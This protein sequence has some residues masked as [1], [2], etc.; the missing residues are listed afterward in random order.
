MPDSDDPTIKELLE[1]GGSMPLDPSTQADL[2]RWFGLPSVTQLEEEGKTA[3]AEDEEMAQVIERRN[4]ALA[5]V[6]PALLAAING[7]TE[8]RPV[9]IVF[10]PSIDLVID[11]KT[12]FFDHDMLDRIAAIADP[13]EVELSD[14]LLD[15]LKECTPQ[16]LLRDL[17]RPESF[18]DKT[19]EWV[20]PIGEG[21]V[22]VVGEVKTAMAT[23]LRLRNFGSRVELEESRQDLAA[24][25]AERRR[26]WLEY[27]PLLQNR[28]V[29]E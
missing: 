17:H 8:D 4:K 11:E 6:D 21:S 22:D 25:R 24:V 18:W 1:S 15:D 9:P 5:A 29:Q 27:L 10:K 20:D 14:A 28:T 23:S 3:A 7:R 16:A 26:N 2:E 12:A 13:R 19:F